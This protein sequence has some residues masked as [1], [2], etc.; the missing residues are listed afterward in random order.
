M[1]ARKQIAL[2]RA[3]RA[4]QRTGVRPPKER[5][6]FRRKS[7]GADAAAEAASSELG[8]LPRGKYNTTAVPLLLVDGYN[9][10]G[11][12]ARL[13]KRRDR[14]DMEGARRLLLDDLVEYNS[15][16]RYDIVVVFDSAGTGSR[17]DHVESY[18]GLG[19][20][21]TPSADLY[22]E[23]ELRR[24]AAEGQRPVWAAT[25]DRAIQVAATNYGA[26]VMSTKR[27]VEELKGSRAASATLVGEWNRQESSRR[28]VFLEDQVGAVQR[29]V[30]SGSLQ[31]K[32]TQ[33]ERK[34]LERGVE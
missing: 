13:K 22:I 12:W 29:G 21:F 10:I 17:S 3:Y 31:G 28:P 26:N 1:S 6:S 7:N 8:E 30:L 23:Q 27:L 34:A 32:L 9:V 11:Y 18:L 15:P 16:K 20:V 33:R 24:I 19:V 2:V 25:A 5:T 4:R 14:D